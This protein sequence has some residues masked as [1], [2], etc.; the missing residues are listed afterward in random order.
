MKICHFKQFMHILE[1][2][3]LR[4]SLFLLVVFSLFWTIFVQIHPA[5]AQTPVSSNNTS[6]LGIAT[7]LSIKGDNITTGRIVSFANNGYILS[8]IAYDPLTIGVVT[9]NPAVA[10]VATESATYPVVS[11]GDAYVLVS[12]EN[13]AIKKNDLVT[14]STT[15]G[16]GMKAIHSGYVIGSALEDFSP[17]SKSDIG[18][19]LVSLNIHYF[20]NRIT[21]QTSLL[22]IFNLS[23][24][25]TYEQPTTVFK[26]FIAAL[27]VVLSFAFGFW[28]FGQTANRGIEAI[29]RNPLA[30][31]MIQL[32][33]VL[34]VVITVVIIAAGLVVAFFVLRF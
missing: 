22:D 5:F 15:P 25:A 9:Q 34:N 13:G 11:Y 16:V 24:E 23:A 27:V 21:V 3:M 18:L 32:G 2:G 29:G 33:I 12:G 26:Y 19:V 7:Y 30:S 20:A 17:K 4:R 1:K 10:I 14:T 28:F 6:S 31:R 8:K